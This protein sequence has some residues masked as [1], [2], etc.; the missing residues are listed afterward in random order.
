M[1]TITKNIYSIEELKE[2]FPTGFENAHNHWKE[3]HASDIFWIDEIVESFKAIFQHSGIRIYKYELGGGYSHSFVRFDM[4]NEVYNLSG[5]RALAWL[6]NNLFSGLRVNKKFINRV[7][8]Y[9]GKWYDFTK[10]GEIPSCP[11]TGVCYDEDLIESLKKDILS[12]E[13]LGDAYKNLADKASEL[14]EAETEDQ[15]SEEYFFQH[16]EANEYEFYEDGEMA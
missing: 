12:G 11:F 4:D 7:K 9:S 5:N 13:N 14:I 8:E 2:N 10:Y 1:K 3:D 15:M 6:E 16:A